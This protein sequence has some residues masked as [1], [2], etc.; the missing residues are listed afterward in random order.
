MT[1]TTTKFDSAGFDLDQ[2]SAQMSS[3]GEDAVV[4]LHADGSTSCTPN[5]SHTVVNRQNDSEMNNETDSNENVAAAEQCKQ[6][7]NDY[8]KQQNYKM[9]HLKYTEAI[10]CIPGLSGAD[11]LLQKKQWEDAQHLRVRQE[12]RERD[13]KKNETNEV[14]NAAATEEESSAPSQPLSF[15][16]EPPHAYGTLLAVYYCNR[17]AASLQMAPPMVKPSEKEDPLEKKKISPPLQE[18]LDDCT[19]ALLLDPTY[20]KAYVRR[21]TIYERVAQ[22][23]EALSDMCA[24]AALDPTNA[25]IRQHVGRLQ[26]LE[27]ARMEALKEETLE[28]LKDLGNSLLSNFGLSL[29]NF[30]AQKDPNTGSYNIS[31]QN[32]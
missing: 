2:L 28:K 8:Y 1:T 12:L 25:T 16:L 31:F 7:G 3:L 18:A 17:A 4:E 29:D 6:E 13:A 15:V 24:A 27:E 11:I 21:S 5:D 19:I 23:E 32:S 9:A 20:V 26:R 22:T 10:Q 30:K 14:S